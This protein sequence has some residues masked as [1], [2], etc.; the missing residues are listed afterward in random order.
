[1]TDQNEVQYYVEPGENNVLQVHNLSV[2]GGDIYILDHLNFTVK[3]GTI[4]AIVGPNG[5][6]KT[7]LIRALLGLIPYS[8]DIIW[9]KGIRMGYVPQGLLATDIP[10]TVQEFLELKCRID[11]TSCLAAVGLE[12]KILGM[13]LGKLSGGQLQRVLLA[14]SIVDNP[15]VLLFD[16]PTSGVDVGAEEPIYERI[17]QMKEKMGITVLLITHNHHV[18]L[19]YSDYILGLNRKQTFF[20]D[21]PSVGHE[22]IMEIMT[23]SLPDYSLHHPDNRTAGE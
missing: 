9:K 10:V 2:K 23:G 14:W 22:A 5:A 1:M 13:Q 8:G 11:P 16:E 15:D 21:T 17:V 18:V 19:H 20:G 4:L 3:K 12:R 7:T 6:G